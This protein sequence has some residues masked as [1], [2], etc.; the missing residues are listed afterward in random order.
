MVG[1]FERFFAQFAGEIAKIRQLI[2]DDD[3]LPVV[4]LN[5]LLQQLPAADGRFTS[6]IAAIRS[7][8]APTAQDN[9]YVHPNDDAT[10]F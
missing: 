2:D 3:T 6:L 9:P 5:E 8:I 4:E 10:M 7:R 1:G